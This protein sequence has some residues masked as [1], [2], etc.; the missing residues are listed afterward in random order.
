MNGGY[1]SYRSIFAMPALL[2]ALS[3]TGLVAAL[4]G[5]GTLDILSWLALCV[6]VLVIGKAIQRADK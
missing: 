4:L 1:R 3:V 2:G 6:P 5:D